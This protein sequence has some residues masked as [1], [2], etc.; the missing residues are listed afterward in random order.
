MQ[1]DFLHYIWQFKKFHFTNLKSQ[2]DEAIEIHSVG[3]HNPN[4]GPDFFNA[5]IKIN[6]QLW[7][8]NVEIHIKSSDWF[9]HNHEQ[10]KRY[11]NVMLHVVW[12][13]D[14]E[15]FR[16]NNNPIPC[17]ELKKHV[18]QTV[19]KNHQA[20]FNKKN[21]WIH[22][23]KDFGLMDTFF[24]NNWLERLYIERLEQK[25]AFI[26]KLLK[27]S[28]NNW[29][30]VLFKMIAKNFGL[31]VNG[32]AFFS[33]S[34]SFEFSLVRKLHSNQSNLEALLFG[35]A[36]FF[37]KDIQEGYFLKLKE[38]YQFLKRKFQLDNS[39]VVACH[40]FRLRPPN[41]P[42]LRLSQLAMLYNKHQNLFSKIIEAKDVNTFYD[43]FKISSAP[44]WKTHYTFEK[45]SKPSSKTLTKSFID[46]LL[47]NTVLPIKFCYAKNN[48]SSIDEI[49]LKLSQLIQSEK[50]QVVTA[51]H[52]LKKISNTALHSQALIQLKTNYCDAHR[53]LQC[54]IGNTILNK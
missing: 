25:T 9:L 1:E 3:E 5:H 18:F 10:D 23:E 47:I 46:L 24:L 20:L 34:Q 36:G 21:Q 22:C 43:L 26:N 53:C 17:L 54:A 12:E 16:K 52:N 37:E 32:D 4:S 35:Q 19:L 7:A 33:I 42:T 15:I 44:F 31:K 28:K 41:F 14:T 51:F 2:N 11:D 27:Q 45:E 13:N 40:F 39:H 30:A 38:N 49:I 6:G 29:E 50:N 8:G 48:G